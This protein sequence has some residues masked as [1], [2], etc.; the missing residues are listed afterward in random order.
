MARLTPQRLASM[1]PLLLDLA[2]LYRAL[3][4]GAD[5]DLDARETDAMRAA[6]EAWVPGQDPASV[7]HALR[8]AELSAPGVVGLGV[9]LERIAG[10]LDAQG[11][12]RVV[13]DLRRVAEADGRVTG[14]ERDLV[15]LVERA[16]GGA[17]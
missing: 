13:S 3:A 6:L 8:E 4:F 14:N 5:G 16:L 10:R 12:A 9:V 15:G 1:T 17:S 7:S 11:R 2:V